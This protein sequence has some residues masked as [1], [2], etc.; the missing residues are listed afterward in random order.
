MSLSRIWFVLSFVTPVEKLEDCLQFWL[1]EK[2]LLFLESKILFLQK[3]ELFIDK[4]LRNPFVFCSEL[5]SSDFILKTF[6]GLLKF[7]SQGSD[8]STLI[9]FSLFS[10]K[11]LVFFESIDCD[12]AWWF[13]W[14]FVIYFGVT[15]WYGWRHFEW[16]FSSSENLLD[17]TCDLRLLFKLWWFVNC[18]NDLLPEVTWKSTPGDWFKL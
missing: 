3:S 14:R 10:L 7:T 5:I 12:L 8:K 13:S 9:C 11:T 18:P 1:S 15:F 17:E 2:D 4:R 16:K 6:L